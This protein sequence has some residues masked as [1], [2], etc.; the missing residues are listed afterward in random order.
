M[1]QSTPELAKNLLVEIFLIIA[2]P[3][4]RITEFLNPEVILPDQIQ[5]FTILLPLVTCVHLTQLVE[6]SKGNLQ[7]EVLYLIFQL[8]LP[9]YELSRLNPFTVALYHFLTFFTAVA[10][11]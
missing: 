2:V 1:G 9:S 5:K 7:A 10:V 3:C 4:I 11:H 6:G 8:K